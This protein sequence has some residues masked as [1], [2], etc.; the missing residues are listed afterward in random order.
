MQRPIFVIEW[1]VWTILK[2]WNSDHVTKTETILKNNVPEQASLIRYT[3][4][5]EKQENFEYSGF[6]SVTEM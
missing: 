4:T 5:K 3:R 1:T 6:L 2:T